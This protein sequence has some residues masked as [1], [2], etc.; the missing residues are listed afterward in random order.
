M[1]IRTRWFKRAVSRQMER[2]HI[3]AGTVAL[4]GWWNVDMKPGKAID[5]VLDVRDGLPFHEA[6]FIY[7]E[8]FLEHL[9]F[10]EALAFCRESRR[11]LQ[12]SG[13][14]RLTTPNL[15][16]V[17]LTHYHHGEW[18]SPCEAIRDCLMLNKAFHGW[19]HQFLYNAPMLEAL[20]GA[21]GFGNVG[22]HRYGESLI[23]ELRSLEHHETYIDSP[24]LPHV[25]VV[26]AWGSIPPTPLPKEL[27]A[28]YRQAMSLR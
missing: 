22:F 7:A 23:P 24:Q 9:A 2:L 16:W 4:R 10:D 28:D 26:E 14:L 18:S 1:A 5:Q 15:D 6:R 19:G 8:H 17:Y 12:P 13:I 27:V 11:V 21:A 25:L 3:G 20:L